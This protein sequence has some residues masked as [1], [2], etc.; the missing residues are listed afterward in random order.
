MPRLSTAMVRM[1]HKDMADE[2]A[3]EKQSEREY[4]KD[5]P[6][7]S[8]MSGSGATPSMGLSQIR[9]GKKCD[10]AMEQGRELG[11]HLHK[12]HGGQFLNTF[13]DGMG[14]Y[15][16]GLGTGRYEGQGK[17]EGG[18]LRA[19]SWLFNGHGSGGAKEKM[20][21]GDFMGN[22]LFGKMLGKGAEFS[23][24]QQNF[25]DG[26]QKMEGGNMSMLLASMA[27]PLLG[28]LLGNGHI[29]DKCHKE[30]E[31]MIKKHEEKYHKK[32]MKGGFWAPLLM[33]VAPMLLN[34]LLGSGHCNQKGHDAILKMMGQC[35]KKEQREMKKQ[36]KAMKKEMKGSGMARC[37]GAGS[38]YVKRPSPTYVEKKELAVMPT[39]EGKGSDGRKARA[40]IVRQV[41]NEKGMK[42][43]EA[44]RYVKANGLYKP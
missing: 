9:G 21:G 42:L 4:G 31:K 33:S 32:Q 16:G 27:M 36:E 28:K 13:M 39:M 2:R 37:V 23:S 43:I 26:K 12:L 18:D 38:A 30:M 7:R 41:M 11:E 14:K 20:E 3:L 40:E 35:D 24:D 34:K 22:L 44:S 1:A 15:C 5:N 6:L 10:D 29:D 17:M 19:L 25:D 8:D